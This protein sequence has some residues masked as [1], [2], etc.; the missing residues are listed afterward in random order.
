MK[1]TSNFFSHFV[2]LKGP[3]HLPNPHTLRVVR[4]GIEVP[5][6]S[7][8][9]LKACLLTNVIFYSISS[10]YLLCHI[11]ASLNILIYRLAAQPPLSPS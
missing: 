3:T 1:K 2:S 6:L 7:K 5:F 11:L 10:K 8:A 9:P 4:F